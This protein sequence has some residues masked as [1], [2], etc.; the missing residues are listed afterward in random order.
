MKMFCSVALAAISAAIVSAPALAGV[1]VVQEAG[2]S[3]TYATTLNFDEPGG[4][5]G[6]SVPNNSWAGAP[7]NI[8][9]FSSGDVV[10]NDVGDHSAFTG[11]GTNSYQGP[12]G[13]FITFGKDLTSMSFQGWDDSGP[14]GPFGGGAA[15]GI[16]NDGVE[17]ASWFGTPAYGGAGDSWYHITTTDGSVFD[18]VNFLG[19]GFFPQSYVDNLSWNSVPEPGSLMLLALGS[20]AMMRR[21]AR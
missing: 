13:V 15:V 1:V 4:P 20:A 6:N 7:W 8:P 11:Q 5:T 21:R 18:Q 2:P 19:F 3:P 17:V 10:A 14:G 12:F 9:V 16:Y